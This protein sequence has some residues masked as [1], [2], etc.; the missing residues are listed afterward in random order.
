MAFLECD[1]AI[2]VGI[3]LCKLAYVAEDDSPLILTADDIFT[4]LENNI[5]D[6]YETAR[7]EGT[8]DE[9]LDL[10]KEV[11][12]YCINKNNNALAD[13]GITQNALDSKQKTWNDLK[14]EK[15]KITTQHVGTGRQRKILA[16][17]IDTEALGRVNIKLSEIK[18]DVKEATQD[19]AKA[20]EISNEI[21][22]DL[23]LWYT[24]YPLRARDAL[25]KHGTLIVVPMNEYYSK[26]FQNG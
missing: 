24:K 2:D 9:A 4:Y 12:Y 15:L 18:V 16:R 23:K 17:A 22:S 26:L 11:E 3:P 25:I 8:V 21:N 19:R 10:I 14:E 1:V 20:K 7:I 13:V 5:R 6:G